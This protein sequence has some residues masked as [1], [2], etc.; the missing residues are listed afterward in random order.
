M[1]QEKKCKNC[2]YFYLH[3]V[4]SDTTFAPLLQGHCSNDK[5]P[6]KERK[7]NMPYNNCCGLWESDEGK[8]N[9]RKERIVSM[10]KSMRTYL[11]H[12]EQI[13]KEDLNTD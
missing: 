11:R 3:Y 13:L 7:Y 5:I 1:E 6:R 8:K 9:E 10:L 4:R 2:K 12:I